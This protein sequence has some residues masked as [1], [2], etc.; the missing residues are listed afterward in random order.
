M[1]FRYGNYSHPVGE[2]AYR[3]IS[4]E[5]ILADNKLLI[6]F[7]Q[8]WDLEGDLIAT[9]PTTVDAA[10]VAL[11]TAYAANYQD[12]GF[13]F[14]NGLRS[15]LWMPGNSA[16]GGV[17]VQ[18]LALPE[19]KNAVYCTHLPFA[20][21]LVG[22]HEVA[23]GGGGG[24]ALAKWNESLAF[25]GGGPQIV[26]L[27]S[28]DQPPQAQVVKKFTTYK[29]QQSGEAVGLTGWPAP[30]APLFTDPVVFH[31]DQARVVQFTP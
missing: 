18:T 10:L 26:W 23:G 15:N 16:I 30:A 7:R 19:G 8:T 11:A 22:E 6:G 24:P 9:D 2:V 21:R 14:D 1:Y 5:A 31:Q 3:T 12:A 29:A 4:K 27:E 28:I 20:V 25:W 17:L 13:F